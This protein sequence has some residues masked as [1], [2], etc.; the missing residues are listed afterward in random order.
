MGENDYSGG[1]EGGGPR[2]RQT[3][4]P[5]GGPVWSQNQKPRARRGLGYG[6]RN[7]GGLCVPIE[8]N[9]IGGGVDWV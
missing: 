7:A 3:R 1:G 2:V 9:P 5:R 6:Q 8:G 4:R